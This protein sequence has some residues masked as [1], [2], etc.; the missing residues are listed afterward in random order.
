ML[1]SSCKPATHT[2]T[3][4]KQ[5]TAVSLVPHVPEWH[6]NANIYEVHIRHYTSEGSFSAFQEHLPRLKDMGVD[7]LWLMPIHPVSEV[8]RKGSM[9]SP[10]AVGDY[11]G[12]NPDMGS[13]EDFKTLLGAIHQLGMHCIIDW[14]PNH[15]GWDNPWIFNHPEWYTKGAD[16]KITDPL[17][18]HTGESWGWEDVADLN[19]DVPEMRQGMIDAMAFWVRDIGVDGFRVDVAHGVPLDFWKDCIHQLQVIKPIF[20]LAEAEEPPLVNAGTF[21]MDYAWSMHHLMNDIARTHG[22]NQGDTL[23]LDQGNLVI[24]SPQDSPNKY[25]WDIDDILTRDQHRYAKGFK[26]NFTSNHDENAWA[27]TEFARMGA[28]HKAF[29]VLSV[30]LEG[31]PLIYSGQEEPLLRKL[32]F[33]DKDQIDWK[34]YAYH[35]FYKNLLALKTKN[36][37]LWNGVYGGPLRKLD[38]SNNQDL[39]AFHREKNGDQVVVIINLS[40][41]LQETLLT[42]P[43][44]HLTYTEIFTDQKRMSDKEFLVSLEPWAYRVYSD[45]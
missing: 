1:H 14:V 4:S 31:M 34:D 7:I 26:M 21:I 11:Y 22:V 41:R 12:I 5:A 2:S 17:N 6:K 44:H 8:K 18:P 32:A 27:G 29:A 43:G 9:G 39:Y 42:L 37:A 3:L 25:A 24:G 13:M 36:Q 19:Y 28:G 33:F 23:K 30:T 10:Y 45:K 38:T 20:M 16:G 35:D 40:N 15:S